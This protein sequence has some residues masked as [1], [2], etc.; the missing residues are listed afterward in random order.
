MANLAIFW[1][2]WVMTFQKV[3]TLVNM[4][5]FITL[6]WLSF[7]LWLFWKTL[8]FVTTLAILAILTIMIFVATFAFWPSWFLWLL[9]LFWLSSFLWLFWLSWFGFAQKS[10]SKIYLV[11]LPW[12][13][14]K[15]CLLRSQNWRNWPQG[16]IFKMSYVSNT[17][18]YYFWQIAPA[19]RIAVKLQ[20]DAIRVM[21][22][23][24]FHRFFQVGYQLLLNDIRTT[25][26]SIWRRFG[27]FA[28]SSKI[29]LE[30]DEIF[31]SH[32][33][34]GRRKACLVI[35]IRRLIFLN[36]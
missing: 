25:A 3:A 31:Q 29:T 16:A 26:S 34:K 28:R 15:Y 27:F 6:L 18:I 11:I 30:K 10:F 35:L 8:N 13:F 33:E 20:S 17:S 5:I 21:M 2:C 9:L 23:M 19:R 7:L 14:K 12:M 36:F 22:P 4:A 32:E 1:H 24:H